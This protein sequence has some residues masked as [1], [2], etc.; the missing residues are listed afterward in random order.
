M[1]KPPVKM[2]LQMQA[3]TKSIRTP[4]LQRELPC[5]Y[6]EFIRSNLY[7]VITHSFPLFCSQLT[8]STVYTLVDEWLFMHGATEPEFHHI[9]TEFV[10]FIHQRALDNRGCH[11]TAELIS[12]IEYE[13]IIF[14]TE[15]DV[16]ELVIPNVLWDE[17]DA[18]PDKF[19]ILL[20]ST[21]KLVK[22]PFLINSDSVTFMTNKHQTACYGVFRNAF[23][24]VVSQKLRE[25]D[26]AIIQIIQHTPR[27]TFIQLQQQITQHL[28]TFHVLTWVQEFHQ[29]GLIGLYISGET[30]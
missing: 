14:S 9:A 15:I 23:H 29:N 8:E 4:S 24:Q 28:S 11:L 12:I 18:L 27:L 7:S 26:I 22:V 2:S 10:K 20:N 3:L 30:I 16:S 19:Y 1:L 6:Q 17:V 25:V 5:R 21:L 13:W